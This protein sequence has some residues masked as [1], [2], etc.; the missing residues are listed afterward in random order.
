MTSAIV[1]RLLG[2]VLAVS[3]GVAGFDIEGPF[4]INTPV[5]ETLTLSALMHSAFGAPKDLTVDDAPLDLKE[6]FRGDMWNDDPECQLFDDKDDDNWD[7]SSGFTWYRK[8][9]AAE[10]GDPDVE[11]LIGRS[12]FWDLQFL[13]SMGADIG[14][15]PHDTRDKIMLWLEVAYKLSIGEGGLGEDDAISSVPI[16]SGDYSLSGFFNSTTKP[17]GSDNLFKLFACSTEFADVDLRR[18]AIGTCLHVVQDSYAKG[19]TRRELLNPEDRVSDNSTEF[20]EGT[21]AKLGAIENFH[22]YKDQGSAHADLDHWDSDF[23]DMNPAEPSSFNSLWGARMGQEKG[24]KLLDFW[25]A[26]IKWD[27]GVKE[28]L[29]Q[30][31]FNLSPKAT[32]SDNTV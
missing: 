27:E 18:R 21:Y 7:F 4:D 29:L 12:H 19:H 24:A 11:N 16:T 26:G 31:V 8:F 2:A 3:Q 30:E 17:T 5:H 13:H 28:W 9:L 32:P 1:I 10:H 15:M 6:F 20:A 22:S 14:E 23:P 25:D